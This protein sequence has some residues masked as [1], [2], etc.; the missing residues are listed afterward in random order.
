MQILLL[1]KKTK[2]LIRQKNISTQQ[3]SK[4]VTAKKKNIIKEGIFIQLE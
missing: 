3:N 2:S 1:N 4:T